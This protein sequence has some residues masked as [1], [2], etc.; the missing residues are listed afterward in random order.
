MEQ[1]EEYSEFDESDK[2]ETEEIVY[3]ISFD[4]EE[5]QQKNRHFM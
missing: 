4:D 3:E 2:E 1:M 5:L